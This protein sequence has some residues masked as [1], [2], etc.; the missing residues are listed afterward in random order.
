MTW[1]ELHFT[2]DEMKCRGT[3]KGANLA[4]AAKAARLDAIRLLNDPAE[5]R[6]RREL[7]DQAAAE[8]RR[9]RRDDA[10]Q[11]KRDNDLRTAWRGEPR[12]RPRLPSVERRA[13]VER[14]LA[15]PRHGWPVPTVSH[16]VY[17]DAT[18]PKRK[19]R[20]RKQTEVAM[21]EIARAKAERDRIA[22][23]EQCRRASVAQ[24]EDLELLEAFGGSGDDDSK[25]GSGGESPGK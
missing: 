11:R 9:R 5:V 17:K 15:A 3:S 18:D 12:K 22:R 24:A 4:R 1:L 8:R 6:R 13:R 19:E 20:M 7:A 21:E 14:Q 25:A 2:A 23:A 16:R 10:N